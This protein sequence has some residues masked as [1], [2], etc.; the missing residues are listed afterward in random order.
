MLA[1]LLIRFSPYKEKKRAKHID[2][3]ANK[4]NQKL[5]NVRGLL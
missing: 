5:E 3:S 2:S 4:M 1:L